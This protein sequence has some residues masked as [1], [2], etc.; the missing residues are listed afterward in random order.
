MHCSR[1]I[2]KS[3][4]NPASIQYQNGKK[5]RAWGYRSDGN[6]H[7]WE[8]GISGDFKLDGPEDTSPTEAC[9]GGNNSNPN[10]P[11]NPD[12]DTIWTDGDTPWIDGNPS[13]IDLN[14]DDTDCY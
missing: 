14:P 7:V 5:V 6:V 9:G 2:Y 11:T 3:A 1:P 13:R 12:G 8:P 10:S 4:D